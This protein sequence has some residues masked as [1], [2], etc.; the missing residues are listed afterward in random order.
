MNWPEDRLIEIA[1]RREELIA[2]AGAQRASVAGIFDE[3]E[4]PAAIADRALGVVRFLRLHPVSTAVAVAAAAVVLR[5]QG[6]EV[7]S[8][9]GRAVAV[10]RLWRTVSEWSSRLSA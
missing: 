7:L 8:L 3:L 2:R 10:W 9:A 4:A 5:R 6:Q 1:R